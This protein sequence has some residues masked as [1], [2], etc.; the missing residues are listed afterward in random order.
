MPSSLTRPF[1]EHPSTM[2]DSTTTLPM[3]STYAL[4]AIA[5]YFLPC[6]IRSLYK[7]FLNIVKDA[8]SFGKLV[9]SVAMHILTKF[10]ACKRRS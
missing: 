9:L 6:L 2:P 1:G 4:R 3:S 10:D 5:S 7:M 8:A